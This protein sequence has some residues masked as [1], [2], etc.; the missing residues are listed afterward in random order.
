MVVVMRYAVAIL[1]ILLFLLFLLLR[2]ISCR[3]NEETEKRATTISFA[4]SVSSTLSSNFLA[5][6]CGLS[7]CTVPPY[8]LTRSCLTNWKY[9]TNTDIINRQHKHS[10]LDFNMTSHTKFS[11]TRIGFSSKLH[12]TTLGRCW[13]TSTRMHLINDFLFRLCLGRSFVCYGSTC[14]LYMQKVKRCTFGESKKISPL[15]STK[16]RSISCWWRCCNDAT[17]FFLGGYNNNQLLCNPY[18]AIHQHLLCTFF[19]MEE[20]EE[21]VV[22][23]MFCNTLQEN[24]QR[25]GNNC[26]MFYITHKELAKKHLT[27]SFDPHF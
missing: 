15:P 14:M 26:R 2:S 27:T 5:G 1:I 25:Y 13:S 7:N 21:Y 16:Q 24:V 12:A 19:K 22:K 23:K 6:T 11:S 20:Q 8:P 3:R 18:H 17:N 9:L 10:T 4:S